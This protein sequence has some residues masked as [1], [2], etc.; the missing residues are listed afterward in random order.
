M[1]RTS[2]LLVFLLLGGILFS[3][4]L[5]IENYEDNTDIWVLIPFKTFVFGKEAA[6]V[7]YQIVIS[8]TDHRKRS[9]FTSVK[10]IILHKDTSLRDS[11]IPVNLRT[12]LPPNRYILSVVLKNIDLGGTT[13]LQRSF[14]LDGRYTEIGRTFI[15]GDV[16]GMQF[17]PAA[18]EQ[19]DRPMQSCTLYQR[20]SIKADSMEVKLIK[21]DQF[22]SVV[23]EEPRMIA[24]DILPLIRQGKPAE[25]LVTV[26]E[27]NIQYRTS[28]MMYNKWFSYHLTYSLKDQLH[29]VRYIASQ[30]EWNTLRRLSDDKLSVTLD[31]FWDKHD[32]SPGTARNEAR[33]E[34]YRRVMH[35]DEKFTIHK[36]LRGWK[37]DRG[38]I[39]IKFGAPDDIVTDAFPTGRPP[40]I[41]WYYLR[42][43]KTFR[44]IDIRGYGDYRLE[45]TDEEYDH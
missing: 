33:E 9:V 12:T 27:D 11:A 14:V 18:W 45:N 6:S 40:S 26:Y 20:M 5:I 25:I 13:I 1:S 42:Q 36:R 22:L 39:Y 10:T 37:S 3:S 17:I 31:Q 32:P 28:P 21:D 2:M 41:I 23:I 29:Q 35:T 34:F 38:R 7:N 16:G 43:N 8:I 19:F 4:E 30:N 44:F 24:Q 15:I